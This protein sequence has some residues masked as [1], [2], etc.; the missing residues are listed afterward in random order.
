MIELERGSSAPACPVPDKRVVAEQAR[1]AARL[2]DLLQRVAAGDK[3]AFAELYDATSTRVYGMVIRV[4]RNPA[5]SEEAT[6]EVYLQ[7]WR[8]A[9]SFDPQRGS[10]LA[11]IMTL[12]HR[13]AIDR[14]R[15]EQSGADRE[16]LYGSRN[17][18]TDHDQV[19]ESVIQQLESDAV[20]HCLDTLTETQRSTVRLAYYD[21]LTYREVA[22]LLSTPLSTVK[23]RIRDGLS[24]LR[25]CLEV[26]SRE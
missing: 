12:A 22:E 16:A 23:T 20:V 2:Q 10:A 26:T 15:S 1:E 21:G 17:R 6:Q 4:L 8:S 9:D 19:V 24:R 7:I 3:A 25:T 13:R 18:E 14:V 5:I 11:W